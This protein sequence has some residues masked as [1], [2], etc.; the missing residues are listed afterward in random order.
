[1]F[2]SL[3]ARVAR[4]LDA[5]EL[6]YMIIGGQAVLLHGEPRLTRGVDVTL[7]AA[8]ERLADVLAVCRRVGLTP[9]VDPEPFVAE[10]L[11]LPCEEEATGLRVDFVFSYEG[12]ERDALRR[13]VR[14]RVGDGEARFAS[15]EDLVILKVVAGRPRDLEDVRGVLLRTPGLD[16]DAVRTWLR[17]FEEALDL[18]L[19]ERFEAVRREVSG[20]QASA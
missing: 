13:A 6:P 11:V 3:I 19:V 7:G 2:E 1:M 10:T 4:A 8:P 14:V 15:A 18:P 5:R 16:A 9:L 17:A 12:F 20:D